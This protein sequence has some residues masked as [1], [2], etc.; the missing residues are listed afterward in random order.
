[1]SGRARPRR[2]G[3]EASGRISSHPALPYLV[4]GLAVW[5]LF[6]ASLD[7]DF[8][9]DDFPYILLNPVLWLPRHWPSLFTQAGA[10]AASP[11]LVGHTYRPVT[12]LTWG[13][14][15]WLGGANAF[16][17][18]AVDHLLHA[19]NAM[20][21]FRLA[22]RAGRSRPAAL[23]G[24]LVFAC[25]PAMVPSVVYISERSTLLSG[26]F[27]LAALALH[28]AGR[29]RP[30]ARPASWALTGLALL[31]RESAVIWPLTFPLWDYVVRGWRPRQSDGS[32]GRY[33]V[34]FLLDAGYLILR[35]AVLGRVA[36]QG[37]WGA[38]AFE[39]AVMAA[40]GVLVYDPLLALRPFGLRCLYGVPMPEHWA[41][42][43]LALGLWT[44]AAAG[45]TAWLLSRRPEWALGPAWFL[46]HLLPVANI[47]PFAALAG[48]QFLYA[49]L[50]GAA[51][52]VE[53]ALRGAGERA[54]LAASLAAGLLI[55]PG[56]LEFQSYFDNDVALLEGYPQR[57]PPDYMN[58][59]N[60]S[61]AYSRWRMNDRADAY[62]Q[63]ALLDRPPPRPR[64]LALMWLGGRALRRSG[65]RAASPYLREA[66]RASPETLADSGFA[67]WYAGA[68][69]QRRPGSS[70]PSGG[71][72]VRPGGPPPPGPSPWRGG[73]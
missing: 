52:L 20:L 50:M 67:A 26:F 49:P 24:A 37:L 29:E 69:A 7:S 1:M 16:W 25:H 40:K 45:A 4:L 36:Q 47:V 51:F 8:V 22:E 46:A 65:P 23:A 10:M 42:E 33:A 15:A 31:S 58:M 34:P 62:A 44:C 13:L 39:H 72:G 27:G 14:N 41:L 38:N 73:S 43:S 6:Y 56:H 61:R 48:C 55:L 28:D 2:P 66:L 35:T 53:R 57:E 19:A 5:A 3:A 12:A 11:A 68:C 30:A 59:L 70:R 60:L 71:R 32:A 54:I 18:H 64:A 9:G 63:R 21:L 17:F